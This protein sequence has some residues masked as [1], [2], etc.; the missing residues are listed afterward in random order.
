MSR[1]NM[2]AF[3]CIHT[4]NPSSPPWLNEVKVDLNGYFALIGYSHNRCDRIGC[5][6]ERAQIPSHPIFIGPEHSTNMPHVTIGR[7]TGQSQSSA[8]A[9]R[10]V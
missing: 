8:R 2:G 4:R 7:C 1:S 9:N 10:I 6:I 3:R 5:K